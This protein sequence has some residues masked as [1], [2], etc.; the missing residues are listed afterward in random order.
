MKFK[1]NILSFTSLLVFLFFISTSWSQ[2]TVSRQSFTYRDTL[3]LDFYSKKNIDHTRPLLVVVHGGGFF[4]GKRD[5][6]AEVKFANEMALKGYAVASIS[7]RL[8]RKGK[9]FGCNCPSKEK[10]E[11]FVAASEDIT[12]AVIFLQKNA[13][14][15]NIDISKTILLGSSAGAEGV[16]NTVFMKDDYRFKHIS[17]FPVAGVISLSGAMLNK[18]YITE[19]NKIPTLF[20]HGMKDDLVPY[21]SAPH[22]YCNKDT[23]G[24]IILDGAG[25]IAKRLKELHTPYILAVD[26]KGKHEWSGLGYTHTDLI[27]MFIERLVVKNEFI[28]YTIQLK[29]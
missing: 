13:D 21:S 17:K 25:A 22:H 16:L 4:G 19:D 1:R 29:K 9:S 20:F 7:Y 3:K 12:D 24:Y 10:I 18:E 27:L 26:P 14:E 5:N 15:L 2:E 23:E 6:P 8:T 28:Q 11:T